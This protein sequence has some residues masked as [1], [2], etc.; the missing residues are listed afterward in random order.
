MAKTL[1]VKNDISLDKFGLVA[2]RSIQ[3]ALTQAAEWVKDESNDLAPVDTGNLKSTA[4]SSMVGPTEVEVGYT[5]EYAAAVHEMVGQKL[6]GQPRANFGKTRSGVSFGGGS[7]KGTY[8]ETGEPKF[9]EKTIKR[10]SEILSI[11]KR[12][13]GLK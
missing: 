13:T 7:G 5:A 4:Y 10:T 11:L 9:L 8:W 2:T 6:K 1:T 12:A 3:N